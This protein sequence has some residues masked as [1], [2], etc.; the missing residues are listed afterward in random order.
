MT[1]QQI[2]LE[3][4]D[5]RFGTTDVRPTQVKRA[6]NAAY[7]HVWNA[8]DWSFKRVAAANLTVTSGDETPT[9]PTDFGKSRA[10]FDQ[11]GSQLEYL[12]ATEFEAD[13]MV[14]TI[15]S[16]SPEAYTIID[17]QVYLG[18]RPGTAATFKLSYDRRI[19]HL[20][21]G[22][23]VTPSPMTVDTDVPLW[24]PEH[25]YILV[26]ATFIVG[27]DGRGLPATPSDQ[28]EY[29]RQLAAM[30]NDLIGTMVGE[31]VFW[32]AAC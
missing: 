24:G 6:I 9:V 28:A 16:G 15:T 29:D 31:P 22:S 23:V 25:H 1:F 17:R 5:L 14:G 3:C 21:T 30:K 7:A 8:A 13:Y 19:C 26:P 10:V 4:I 12:P 18:P 32:G 11:F 2:M 27:A 20:A